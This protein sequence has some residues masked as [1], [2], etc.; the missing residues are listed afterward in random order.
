V[1]HLFVFVCFVVELPTIQ[2]T[3]NCFW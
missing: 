1:Y 3:Y 2:C